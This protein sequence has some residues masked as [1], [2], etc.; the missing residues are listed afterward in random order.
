MTSS[1]TRDLVDYF[2][3]KVIPFLAATLELLNWS[4]TSTNSA[5]L[6]ASTFHSIWIPSSAYEQLDFG[7]CPTC[8]FQ[9]QELGICFSL[10]HHIILESSYFELY[11]MSSTLKALF[12]LICTC[13]NNGNECSFL[14]LASLSCPLKYG[15]SGGTAR[16]LNCV[17]IDVLLLLCSIFSEIHLSSLK[18]EKRIWTIDSNSMEKIADSWESFWKIFETILRSLG[19]I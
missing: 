8:L 13:C 9:F 17:S 4:F 1:A 5:V 14:V 10:L 11:R 6:T 3:S 19:V 18:N 15:P 12:L 16:A 2:T 7:C